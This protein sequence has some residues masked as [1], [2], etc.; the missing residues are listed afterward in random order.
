MKQLNLRIGI[1]IK[2]ENKTMKAQLAKRIK[3]II[4]NNNFPIT[5]NRV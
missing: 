4:N 2:L 5:I 3:H 1:K